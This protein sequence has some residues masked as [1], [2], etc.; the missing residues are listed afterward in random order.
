LIRT[1]APRLAA[2][3]LLTAAVSVRAQELQLLDVPYLAQSESL[4]GGAAA[5]M[6]MRFWGVTN[7][8]A[9][10]FA[11]LVDPAAAGIH[12]D[13]LLRALRTRGWGAESFRGDSG[14]LQEAL[15]GRRPAIVLIEDRP[16]RFHYVVIVGWSSSRVVVHDPAR[17]PFRVLDERTF[18]VEWERSGYW[19]VVPKPPARP[20]AITAAPTRIPATDSGDGTAVAAVPCSGM[21]DEGVRLAN[22][23]ALT[24]ARVALEAA[25]SAC[26]QSAAAW[27]ELAGLHAQAAEWGAAASAAR[28]ALERDARDAHAARILATALYLQDDADGALDAWNRVGEPV[29]DLVNIIGLERTRYSVASRTMG[30]APQQLLTRASLQAARRKLAELPAAEAARVTFRPA[31]N[32]RAQVDAVLLERPLLPTSPLAAGV[33]ALRAATDRE[34]GVLMSSPSGGGETWTAAW[35]WWQHR[36]RAALGFDA[37]APFGGNWGVAAFTERQSYAD[38]STTVEE[39][40][41]RAEFH[42]TNWTATGLRWETALGIDR[43]RE[44]RTAALSIR[45]GAHQRFAADRA[46]LSASAESW[47]AGLRTWTISVRSD[48]RSRLRNDGQVWIARA[49]EEISPSSAPLALWSGGGTGQGRDVLL[50]AHPLLH[51]GI[52][53]GVFG[54]GLTHGGAEWRRWVQPAAKPLRIAPALFVDLARSTRGLADSDDR[55][56]SDVGGGL[57]IAIPGSGV[58]RLDVARGLRDGRTAFS[59]GWVR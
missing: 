13:D 22:N 16:G 2:A 14:S 47:I 48:W 35:R 59:I 37:P 56:H 15:R 32:G 39:S 53:R 9:E 41:S 31:E 25:A 27:R 7:V 11:D 12:A 19:T 3:V 23:G 5:A 8:Y 45:A 21:V 17:A 20:T 50:R 36:P 40:R 52:I 55:W 4:C 18:I 49:G 46:S 57:R 28:Q 58:L 51:D 26:P 34:V 1:S 54:A 29:I 38:A 43:W 24:R 33:V 6:V 30:L 44:S 42:A 10:T